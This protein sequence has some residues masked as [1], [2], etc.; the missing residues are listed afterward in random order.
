MNLSAGD[1]TF[2]HEYGRYLQSRADGFTYLTFT[3]LPDLFS[4][5]NGGPTETDGNARA[6]LYFN[7]HY[8]LQATNANSASGTFGWYLLENPINDGYQAP[9]HQARAV[10][11]IKEH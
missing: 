10:Q 6:L 8:G 1:P 5:G 2:Q 9:L 11:E 7:K 4:P 3:A